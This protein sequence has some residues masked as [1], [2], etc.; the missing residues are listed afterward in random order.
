MDSLLELLKQNARLT[1]QELVAML[2][3]SED[4]IEKEIQKYEDKGIIKGYTAIVNEDLA[5]DDSVM[6]V[7]EVKVAPESEQGHDEIAKAIMDYEEVE[8]VCLM[9][10]A[11]D[12]AI[13]VRGSSLREVALFVSQRLATLEGVLSTVTHFIL[14][15]YKDKGI[16]L[17][18][19]DC[20][21]RSFVSP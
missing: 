21:E 9:S 2:G 12:L 8:G 7:I 10:G 6:A 18:D 14:K 19:S 20:D 5:S 17:Y 13:T 4:E 3:K 1:N 11:Y 16:M 15:K